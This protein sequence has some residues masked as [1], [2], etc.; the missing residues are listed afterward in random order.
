MGMCKIP[1][2]SP[3]VPVIVQI[4]TDQVFEP[5]SLPGWDD[6][7]YF[8]AV[9][10]QGSLSAASR[11][12]GVEHSTVARRV[13]TLERRIGVRLFDRLPRSWTL[14]DEGQA[15]VEPAERLEDEA[16]AFSRAAT[17][18]PATQGRV[19]VSTPPVFGSHF[20]L[21]Q[22]ATH[23]A[24]WPGIV[25][26]VIGETRSVNLHRREADV[27]MRLMRPSEPGLAA[28]RLGTMSMRLYAAPAW[29]TRPEAA[30]RFI[31][32]GEPL[33]E[34][35]QQR[36]LARIAGER[37]FVLFT[38]DLAALHHACGAGTGHAAEL[39]CPRR[40]RAGRGTGR[41]TSGVARDLERDPSGR[42]PF[43]TC[44]AD[45]RSDRRGGEGQQRAA[46]VN[47]RMADGMP[48]ACR[49]GLPEKK[50]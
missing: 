50:T 21:P 3:R 10:R 42:S 48:I 7:R 47:V 24:R 37:P 46:A 5:S 18:A 6:I 28:R 12:L 1:A 2:C 20:L 45:G 41:R 13:A 34:V 8:L 14:T 15:L 17:A 33:S 38:N 30:W 27:A 29:L 36:L 4:S 43:A 39:P 44:A 16:L 25:L 11:Q 22:L 49:V 23:S 26:D 35:P 40:R 32:Y 31:G 19:R 9:A